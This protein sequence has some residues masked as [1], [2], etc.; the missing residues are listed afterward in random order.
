M[1]LLYGQ[2]GASKQE[3]NVAAGYFSNNGFLFISLQLSHAKWAERA[4]YCKKEKL[5]MKWIAKK[6]TVLTTHP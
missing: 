4:L 5:I 6:Q 2:L 1:E 3:R